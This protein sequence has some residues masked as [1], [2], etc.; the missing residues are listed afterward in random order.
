MHNWS[1]AFHED[2]G[3]DTHMFYRTLPWCMATR[4]G[5]ISYADV[6][7]SRELANAF[8]A[9]RVGL[10]EVILLVEWM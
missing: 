5:I 2:M 10:N 7:V 3:D 4:F 9:I 8:E 6:V 1:L